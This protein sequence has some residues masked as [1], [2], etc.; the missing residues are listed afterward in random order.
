MGVDLV[1]LDIGNVLLNWDPEGFYDRTMG[2]V[3]RVRMFREVPLHKMNLSIDAGAPWAE[4]VEE[5]AQTYARWGKDIRS[6]HTHWDKMAAP[7][8]D[9]SVDMMRTLRAKGMPVWALTNFGRETFDYA[10]VLYPVLAEF[11]GAVVS[12][13]LGIL[14]PEAGIYEAL[15]QRTGVDPSRI[16]FTDD[17]PEN[18][19]AA[20]ARG[21]QV[22]HFTG[23]KGWAQRLVAEGLLDPSEARAA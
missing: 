5:T 1:V 21:W 23:A 12:G 16:L 11:D 18:I 17:R 15:E 2:R 19:A 9:D 14:K 20:E 4:T 22:H 7:L 8:I 6:W 10:Q 3:A 13:H